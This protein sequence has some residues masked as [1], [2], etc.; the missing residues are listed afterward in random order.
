MPGTETVTFGHFTLAP[1]RRSLMNGQ[2][3]VAIGSRA[4]DILIHLV[5]RR[6]DTVSKDELL[7]TVWPNRIVE[8]NNLTVHMSALRRILGSSEEGLDFVQTVAGRGYRFVARTGGVASAEAPQTVPPAAPAAPGRLSRPTTRFIGRQA[9]LA[10]LER[11]LGIARL[12]TIT[13]IG[14]IGKTRTALELASRHAADYPDGTFIAEL[15]TIADPS[16]VAATIAA[17]FH[18]GGADTA[19][20]LIAFLAPLRAML[21]LDNCEHLIDAVAAIA[22][23]IR[24]GCPG[25]TILATSRESLSIEGESVYRLPL[26]SCPDPSVPL[27]AATALRYDAVQL[28]VDRAAGAGSEGCL[29][30]TTAPDI[31][32][33]CAQLDGIPLAIEMAAPR[34]RILNAPQLIERLGERFRL[35]TNNNRFALPRHRTLRTVFDWSFELLTEGE[36]LL[37]HGL[38]VFSGGATLDA[39]VAVAGDG[40]QEEW[41]VLDLLSALVDKSLVLA[42]TMTAG[43]RFQVLETTRQY[44]LQSAA[45][46]DVVARRRS[47]AIWFATLFERA[48]ATWADM[49]SAAW[50]E[51]HGPEVD[52]LRAALAWA[53]GPDGDGPLALRLASVSYP[54]WWDLPQ[55]PLHEHRAWYDRAVTAIDAE[56]PPR[57]AALLWF[58]KSWRDVRF[59]DRENLPAAANAVALFR[60]AGDAVGLGAAL[61]RAGSATLTAETA[62]EAEAYFDEALTT[63][64]KVPSTKWLAL[65]LVK[66]GDL[67]FRKGSLPAALAAYEEALALARTS[68]F[69]YGLMNGGSNM[70]ELLFHLGERDRALAQLHEL[71][72]ALLPGRRTPLVATMAAHLLLAGKTAEAMAAVSE[73]VIYAQ[74]I[75]LP[76]ALAWVAEV[77]ALRYASEDELAP[78]ARLAGYARMVHPSIATRAGSRREIARRLDTIL[79]GRLP[80]PDCARFMAEGAR[81]REEQAA[82][83]VFDTGAG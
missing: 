10:E 32:R 66:R 78:A 65:V 52:N 25:I 62:G 72:D 57:T 20:R 42:D 24:A 33:I 53:F 18:L 47:H 37:L 58:G 7:R 61:W 56:T 38:A 2:K 77:A 1:G 46:A 31:A 50:L 74:A 28:F 16:L 51:I 21:I 12:V 48:E 55:L 70:A 27:D 75:G 79:A 19:E 63:L 83:A 6:P 9:E 14:G 81:W 11:R 36:R 34:L 17:E 44:I 8:E 64:R 49:P 22:R 68:G 5:E 82:K 35:L 54:L 23:G 71:R 80:E 67:L 41:D 30:D 39:V 59:G 4:L 60:Q 40:A 29:D 43:A 15:G 76:A 73:V 45:A 69:W 26:L 13:G 3:P